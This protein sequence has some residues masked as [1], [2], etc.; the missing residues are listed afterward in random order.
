VAARVKVRASAR[1]KV[2]G[3]VFCN[4]PDFSSYGTRD[5]AFRMQRGLRALPV[6]VK[7]GNCS[8]SVSGELPHGGTVSITLYV[9]R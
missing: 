3:T 2:T 1:A 6:A 8:I 5:F 4:S 7:P 9:R